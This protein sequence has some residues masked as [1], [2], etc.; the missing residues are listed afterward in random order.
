MQRWG[1]IYSKSDQLSKIR[2]T[3]P[4]CKKHHSS[5][6]FED[7]CQISSAIKNKRCGM[8]QCSKK[9]TQVTIW[10]KLVGSCV[11]ADV[12]FHHFCWLLGL[13]KIDSTKVLRVDVFSN[14]LVV[15]LFNRLKIWSS[16][17]LV[18]HSFTSINRNIFV[19]FNFGARSV[20]KIR[21]NL[22]RK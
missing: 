1:K 11:F 9:K 7:F 10:K 20:S 4:E 6:Y 14:F 18:S 17:N 5:V 8:C 21:T 3:R 19:G 13:P 15:Y 22:L 16:S 2:L 12:E